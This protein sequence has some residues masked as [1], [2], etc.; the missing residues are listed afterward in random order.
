MNLQ[1]ES[2]KVKAPI[3]FALSLLLS[4]CGGGGQR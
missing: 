4:A 3:I 2:P 1:F